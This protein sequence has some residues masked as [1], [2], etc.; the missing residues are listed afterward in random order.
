MKPKKI[1]VTLLADMNVL[2][3][4]LPHGTFTVN[5]TQYTSENYNGTE[6]TVKYMNNVPVINEVKI[7]NY[8]SGYISK[9]N[10]LLEVQDYELQYSALIQDAYREDDEFLFSTLE[11]EYKYKKF[12]ELWKPTYEVVKTEEPVEIEIRHSMLDTGSKYLESLFSLDTT[13]ADLVCFKRL[14]Y[15]RSILQ[16][17]CRDNGVACEI[18][19]HSG[20]KFAKINSKYVFSDDPIYTDV[21][22]VETISFDAAND[23]MEY[24]KSNLEFKLSS[25]VTPLSAVNKITLS[26]AMDR[27]NSL[28]EYVK[29]ARYTTRTSKDKLSSEV[30]SKLQE[31]R[32]M[33]AS[34]FNKG[35]Q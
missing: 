19:V 11:D 20:L 26:D 1:I 25:I 22:P 4:R 31:L 14:E 15:Q 35:T 21:N 33:I 8:I 6:V 9:N 30:I 24:I 3:F 7:S 23:R 27:I 10:E 28:S 5:G 12:L 13:K 18:P 2:H 34:R 29:N 16:L 32:D 17:W